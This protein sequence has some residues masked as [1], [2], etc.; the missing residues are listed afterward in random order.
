MGSPVDDDDPQHA[1]RV[2][3]YVK[4][5][6]KLAAN[7]PIN[8]GILKSPPNNGKERGFEDFKRNWRGLDP[9]LGEELSTVSHV[10]STTFLV[11]WIGQDNHP[12]RAEPP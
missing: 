11:W 10:A 2:Q 9:C 6:M 4:N 8:G 7:G 3:N 5:D 12:N 1:G